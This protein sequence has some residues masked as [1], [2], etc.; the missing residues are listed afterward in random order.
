MAAPLG[1]VHLGQLQRERAIEHLGAKAVG[2]LVHVDGADDDQVAG[3]ID[4]APVAAIG[5]DG[6]GPGGDGPGAPIQ[7]TGRAR[8]IPRLGVGQNRGQQRRLP[9]AERI[10]PNAEIMPGGGLDPEDA[11]VEL[12]HVQVHLKDAA[13]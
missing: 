1:Q 2:A 8:G 9:R 6:A 11:F 12:G 4:A 7:K 13:L 10:G 5:V 3:Q